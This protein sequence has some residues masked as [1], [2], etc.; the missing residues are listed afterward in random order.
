MDDTSESTSAL[1]GEDLR[2]FADEKQEIL[3]N[4]P[5]MN[6]EETKTAI[7]TDFVN[8][9]GWQ[10]PRDG[11]MEYK[12]GD[13]NTNRVDYAFFHGGS[14]TLFVEA[15]SPAESLQ[16]YRSQLKEY[17]LLDNVDLGI[18]TD[19]ENYEFYQR[20]IDDEGDVESHRIARLSLDEFPNHRPLI[21][22]FSKA[23]VTDESYIERLER[24]NALQSAQQ[25]LGD[26][27]EQIAGEIVDTV[28]ESVGDIAE[29]AAT[30]HVTEYLDSVADDL[31]EMTPTEPTGGEDDD[32][33]IDVIEAETGI[34]FTKGEVH[35]TGDLSA[36]DHLRNLIQVL[37][38]HGFLTKQELPI[39]SGPTR[40]ILNTEPTDKEGKEMTAGEEIVDGVYAELHANAETIKRYIQTLVDVVTT[41]DEQHPGTSTGATSDTPVEMAEQG[42]VVDQQS[43]DPVVPVTSLEEFSDDSAQVGV[44]ASDF[45]RGVPFLLEHNAWGFIR[46][47]SNPEYF[48]IYLNRP[49]QQVHFFGPVD[50]IISQQDFTENHVTDQDLSD[51]ADSKKVIRFSKL[52]QLENPIPVGE[53]SSRMQGLLYTTLGD[54][55][56]AKTTDDL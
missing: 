52:Y 39:A 35:L 29:Q 16:G 43:K 34:E 46:I 28:T 54:M 44:Y 49:H 36:R 1:S 17:L 4:N 50:E 11:N 27:Q 25:R 32:T 56:A 6:E 55:E 19:G 41:E 26:N 12:F 24:I 53:L 51:I 38:T 15:K 30:T 10:I 45:D 42:I 33:P 8:E 22:T 9:L 18:L 2:R 13:H 20:S 47:G 5:Q 48:S 40:Y 14:T 21:S 3:Q 37:F 23:K 7:I 31:A